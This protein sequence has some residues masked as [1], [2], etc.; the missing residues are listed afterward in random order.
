MLKLTKF[1][2]LVRC[3]L[4]KNKTTFKKGNIQSE[5]KTYLSWFFELAL[6]VMQPQVNWEGIFPIL[7]RCNEFSVDNGLASKTYN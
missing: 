6:G 3:A 1:N 2:C 5:K 7:S 4:S